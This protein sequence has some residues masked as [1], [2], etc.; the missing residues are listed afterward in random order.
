MHTPIEWMVLIPLA[1]SLIVGAWVG[2]I[3]ASLDAWQHWPMML[4][5]LIGACAGLLTWLEASE[6][7]QRIVEYQWHPQPEQPSTVDVRIH[8]HDGYPSGQYIDNVPSTALTTLAQ[9]AVN[10]YALTTASVQAA[11]ISRRA[12]EGTMRPKLINAKLLAMDGRGVSVT[13]HG[14]RVFEAMVRTR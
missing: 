6:R 2:A 1:Q 9:M 14:K 8:S 5:P 12:W 3:V 7:G 11:G 4:S 13:A 10:G